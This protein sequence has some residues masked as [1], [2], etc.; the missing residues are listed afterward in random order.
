MLEALLRR[1]ANR[2]R[3]WRGHDL[4]TKA[5]FIVSSVHPYLPPGSQHLDIACGDGQILL[6]FGEI[7]CKGVGIELS[8]RRLCRCKERDLLAIQAD[9]TAGL[10]FRRGSFDVVSLI[11]TVEHVQDPPRLIE[12]VSR[13]L[14]SN[15]LVIVQIP[16]PRFP[17]DLHY[18]LPF[19]GYLPARVQ[20]V[21]RRLLAGEGYGI[22][23]YTTQ[24]SKRDVEK[25][26]ADFVQLDAQDIVY[27]EQVAPDWLKPFYRLYRVS[28]LRQLFP[29]GHL[30]V[31]GKIGNPVIF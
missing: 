9:M 4:G 11:S 20:R 21:Y 23:Y 16:N 30:F 28:V 2:N 12:E 6:A 8:E 18:F 17:I 14:S 5:K 27:P 10:P 26:F 15:G 7:G 24:L 31:Y 29:T 3:L 25:L 1:G 13:V 19:Y 22:D